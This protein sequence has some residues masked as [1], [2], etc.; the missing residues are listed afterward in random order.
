[1]TNDRKRFGFTIAVLSDRFIQVANKVPE[2]LLIAVA[3]IRDEKDCDEPLDAKHEPYR[4][5]REGSCDKPS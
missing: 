1:M 3:E 2:M 5:L 4:G